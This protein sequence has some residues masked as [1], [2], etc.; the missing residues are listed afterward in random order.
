MFLNFFFLLKQ[1]GLPVSLH[2][3][4]ALLG[5][6]KKEVIAYN[7]DDFYAL[8]KTI[9]VKREEHLDLFDRVFGE[10]FQGMEAISKE[11][12]MK[13]PE[14]WLEKNRKRQLTEE[15]KALIEAF[16]GSE[17]LRKR[18]EELLKEQKERHEGGNRWIGT[19]GT[20]PFGNNGFNPQGYRVGGEAS[21]N[22]SGI[23]VWD[24]RDFANLD[25]K[26]ELDTRNLKLALKRL[27]HFTREGAEEELDMETTISKTSRNAGY[28]D[29]A[30]QPSKEN[31]VKVLMFLDIGGSMD[32][33]VDLCSRLFS[34]A[35]HEFK[36]LEYFYFHN[37]IYDYVWKDN[38]M[39][40]SDRTSTY[41]LLHKFN[42]DYKVIIVGDAAMSPYEIMSDSGSVEY[43]NSESGFAWL[44]R[45]KDH[46]PQI[47]WLNPNAEGSW[48]FYQ[49]TVIIREIFTDRMFPA[50][51]EGIERMMKKLR[52]GAKVI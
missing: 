23:K 27:R 19:G 18:F 32:D 21:G 33:H 24:N 4:L 46:F 41:D 31:R 17:E 7:V 39:R 13:I 30:M 43:S 45:V 26:R 25:D 28:L 16:G 51:I 5:A 15:E 8:C 11:Q 40:W 50:T 14:D 2:E 22:R 34:A 9:L 49:S 6:M 3:L 37:C 35:K 10:Y 52:S 29:I 44:N 20:S 1:K 42:R 48:N 47:A 36:H 12:L 38:E